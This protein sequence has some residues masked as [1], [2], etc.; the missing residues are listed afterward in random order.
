M[1]E[2]RELYI[3]IILLGDMWSDFV[4]WVRKWPLKNRL[5]EKEDIEMLCLV[6]DNEGALTII[7]KAYEEF[8]A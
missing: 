7:R 4:H 2:V 5:L 1:I 6:N 3:P 8:Y